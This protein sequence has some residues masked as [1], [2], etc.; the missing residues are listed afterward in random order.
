MKLLIALF[1]FS[2]NSSVSRNYYVS[3]SGD[4]NNNGLTAASP[5]KTLSKVRSLKL[6]AGD[7]VLF[8]R[9]DFFRGYYIAGNSG[10]AGKRII[11]G[12][13]GKGELPI[14]ASSRNVKK[15]S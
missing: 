12:A 14:I 7:S 2:C 6:E 9:G 15:T 11:Y 13:Y 5:F 4:D 8:K 3:T 1:L 10:T